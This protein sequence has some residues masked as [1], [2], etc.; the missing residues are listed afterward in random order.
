MLAKE[1][2]RTA[3]VSSRYCA[4]CYHYQAIGKSRQFCAYILD[5]GRKRPCQFGEGCMVHTGKRTAQA[6]EEQV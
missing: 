4:G 1:I 2:R 3:N 5:T 6:E